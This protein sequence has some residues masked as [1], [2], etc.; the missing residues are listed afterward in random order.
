MIKSILFVCTGNTCRSVMAEHLLKVKAKAMGLSLNVAS[1]GLNAFA[2]DTATENTLEALAKVNIKEVEHRSRRVHPRLLEEFD[3]ILAM[4]KGHKQQL[5]E[6][7]PEFNEKIY[8]LK[9]YVEIISAGQEQAESIEKDYEISDPF[10]QSQAVYNQSLEEIDQAVEAILEH[11]AER[12]N[13]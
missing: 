12:A 3:L 10:G 1:A 13:G 7:A 9:E 5:L 4:T 8:L 6:I 2:G 11:I